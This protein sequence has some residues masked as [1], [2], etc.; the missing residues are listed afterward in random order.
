M[1][2]QDQFLELCRRLCQEP[3]PE[4]Q[5]DIVRELIAL[6]QNEQKDI[7]EKVRNAIGQ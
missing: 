6:L 5:H 3:D 7:N 1:F 4:T 2:D